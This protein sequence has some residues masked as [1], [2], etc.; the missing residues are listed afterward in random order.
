[1]THHELLQLYAHHKNL[2]FRE[3]NLGSPYI[4]RSVP[5]ADI[6]SVRPSYTKHFIDIIEIKATRSDFLSDINSGKFKKYLP[7]CHRFFYGVVKGVTCLKEIQDILPGEHHNVGLTIYNPEKKSWR[8]RYVPKYRDIK[9]ELEMLQSLLFY[10]QKA[11]HLMEPKH[12]R[13]WAKGVGSNISGIS[14][15]VK[16]AI[17]FYRRYYKKINDPDFKEW[18]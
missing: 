4:S 1:M 7:H 12:Y 16:R 13:E 15:R 17:E 5:Q 8:A 2:L 6:V 9:L 3:V 11:R 14:K 10:R 18:T